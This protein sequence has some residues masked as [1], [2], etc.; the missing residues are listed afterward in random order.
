[1]ALG[2]DDIANMNARE[3]RDAL[4][5]ELQRLE[6]KTALLTNG[7]STFDEEIRE[8]A[9]RAAE[10]GLLDVKPAEV[11]REVVL[12][13]IEGAV[14]Q[15]VGRDN[16]RYAK[17][18]SEL[19]SVNRRLRKLHQFTDEYRSYKGNL[20]GAEDSLRPI[21]LLIARSSEV[22]KSEIFDE[23]ISCLKAD[24]VT[25]K[26]SLTGKQPVDG[27]IRAMLKKL[28]VQREKLQQELALLPQESKSF[29]TERDK[30]LFVGETKGRLKLF[31][32]KTYPA[33]IPEK[34][35]SVSDV[36]SEIDAILVRDVDETRDAII[37]VINEITLALLKETGE[38]LANYA[39]YQTDFAYKEKRLRLRKPRSRLIENV[40]SSS[41]HMFLH[42][43]Q[44]LALH[45]VAII[46]QSPF[47][48]N[49]L[50]ID[51]P[52]RPYYPDDKPK[53]DVVLA[54]SDSE[55]VRIA[56]QLL[57]NFVA[58]MNKQYSS[59]FQMI[60]LE[61]VPKNTFDGM[62]FVHVLPE[63]RNGEALIPAS[64]Q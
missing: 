32:D 26:A 30:W 21:Q 59:D 34:A 55:K 51:Q 31:S 47:V 9:L 16:D 43:L 57:N 27:Q 3:R 28:E 35:R 40:G 1:M 10:Y 14:S 7:R 18:N 37:S 56:F 61:H 11:T 44:F 46:H 50:I 45:E 17:V 60:V 53:N 20:Q 42:L 29:A 24:L 25:I 15:D 48:P 19:I 23:L 58:R 64:W 6:R 13:A 22:V 49:F 39:T 4:M 33:S 12:Q 54:N 8:I 52:S 2:I 63:F 36:K 41:N 62:D 38:A 5:R